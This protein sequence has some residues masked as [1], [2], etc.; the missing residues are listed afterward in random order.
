[1]NS[2]VLTDNQKRICDLVAS[3]RPMPLVEIAKILGITVKSARNRLGLLKQRGQL[4]YI[5][6]SR[7]V[8][9]CAAGMRESWA[10]ELNEADRLRRL[11]GRRN[12]LRNMSNRNRNR[13]LKKEEGLGGGEDDRPFV[14]RWV[15]AWEPEKLSAVRSVFELAA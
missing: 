1:M 2:F 6:S 10:M 7:A 14:H 9:W 8:L 3:G 12:M 5:K 4:D 13:Q 15:Q 11:Q